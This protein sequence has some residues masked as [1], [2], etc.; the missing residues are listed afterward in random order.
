MAVNLT[1]GINNLAAPEHMPRGE[2]THDGHPLPQ[3]AERRSCAGTN[4]VLGDCPLMPENYHES[5]M[6]SSL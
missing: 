6:A 2:S 5:K 3:P 1:P 4:I